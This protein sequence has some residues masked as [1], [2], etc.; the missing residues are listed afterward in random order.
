MTQ[1]GLKMS[2]LTLFDFCSDCDRYFKSSVS[3]QVVGCGLQEDIGSPFSKTV[4]YLTVQPISSK[5][6][7][8]VSCTAAEFAI[9]TKLNLPVIARI[10]LHK[11]D[12]LDERE[13]HSQFET[14]DDGAWSE[15]GIALSKM[16]SKDENGT[17][18]EQDEQKIYKKFCDLVPKQE[19]ETVGQPEKVEQTADSV[20]LTWSIP[21]GFERIKAQVKRLK[22]EKKKWKRDFK[23][24]KDL[25]AN[26]EQ[27]ID[28]AQ[29]PLSIF[30][31]QKQQGAKDEN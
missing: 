31:E 27:I 10:C 18:E 9:L 17:T 19:S 20:K 21:Q 11:S 16:L 22:A 5:T 14:Y 7:Y 26:F 30:G 6:A 3:V 2:E 23:A 8:D 28:T 25:T 29:K 1:K 13:T 24:L 12:I 4:P 15:R